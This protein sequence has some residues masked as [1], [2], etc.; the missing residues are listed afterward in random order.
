MHEII[1]GFLLN[2]LENKRIPTRHTFSLVSDDY[3]GSAAYALT[4]L[5]KL[6]KLNP[7]QVVA[8]HFEDSETLNRVLPEFVKDLML[9]ASHVYW[10][11]DLFSKWSKKH[12]PATLLRFVNNFFVVNSLEREMAEGGLKMRRSAGKYIDRTFSSTILKRYPKYGEGVSEPEVV[13]TLCLL[14]E[15]LWVR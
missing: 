2:E 5:A 6:M 14:V 4:R 1:V 12:S 8:L 9:A 3:T 11:M 15:N 10:H 13:R 7:G